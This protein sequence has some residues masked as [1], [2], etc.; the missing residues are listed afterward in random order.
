MGQRLKSSI[1]V[2]MNNAEPLALG[3]FKYVLSPKSGIPVEL[4]I[5]NDV[6]PR[7]LSDQVV[8]C[9]RVK[10]IQWFDMLPFENWAEFACEQM[11]ADEGQRSNHELVLKSFN[12]YYTRLSSREREGFGAKLR[13]KLQN[14]AFLETS[15]GLK[16]P[17]DSFLSSFVLFDD[18]PLVCTAA[19]SRSL[20]VAL[21][22]RDHADLE[23]VFSRLDSLKWDPVALIRYLASTHESF[24]GDEWRRLRLTPFLPI[25]RGPGA[26]QRSHGTAAE[27]S[28]P[29]SRCLSSGF[30]HS[31]G[32]RRK[33]IRRP[34]QRVDSC[35][36]LAFPSTR[37]PLR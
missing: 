12:T 18:L 6:L 2:S 34:I 7:A 4:S 33:R 13:A 35:I 37:V 15:M 14:V 8:S 20:L 30:S 17:V 1:V 16:S 29:I 28:F 10:T 26:E 31:S 11:L 19:C 24:S 5:P 9:W 3:S 23:L 25:R 22:V 21:G 27:C 36:S 32:V